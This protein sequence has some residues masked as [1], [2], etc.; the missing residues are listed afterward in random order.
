MRPLPFGEHLGLDHLPHLQAIVEHRAGT[1]DAAHVVVHDV[2]HVALLEQ[3]QPLEEVD[4]EDEQPNAPRT[5]AA[6]E[7]SLL[8]FIKQPCALS[9]PRP[10]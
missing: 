5:N 7:Y 1:G 2:V 10:I 9:A 6:M 3:V 8:I 4:T